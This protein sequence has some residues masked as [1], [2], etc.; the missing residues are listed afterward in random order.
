MFFSGFQN[1]ILKSAYNCTLYQWLPAIGLGA[2]YHQPLSVFP[3]IQGL[4]FKSV[5]QILFDTYD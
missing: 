2:N 1:C 4:A 3:W 5:G